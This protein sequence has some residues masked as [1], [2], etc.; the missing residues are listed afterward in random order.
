MVSIN[1]FNFNIETEKHLSTPNLI[2]KKKMCES[3]DV[4]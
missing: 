3:L 4:F 1:N 2:F